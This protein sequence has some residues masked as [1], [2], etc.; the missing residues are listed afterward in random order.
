MLILILSLS[1][2]LFAVPMKSEHSNATITQTQN[3]PI[4]KLQ[5]MY[6]REAGNQMQVSLIKSETMKLGAKATPVLIKVMKESSY[7]E[8]NRWIATFMLGRVMGKKASPFIAKFAKH[9]HWMMRVASLK[10]LL[11]L[12]DFRYERIFSEALK[13]ESLMVRVQALQNISYMKIKNLGPHVWSMLYD[14]TN[15]SGSKGNYKRSDIVKNI[16][17]TLGD[18]DY[19]HAKKPLLKMVQNKK[20]NDVFSEL[21]YTLVKLTNKTSPKGSEEAKRTFWAKI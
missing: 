9:P 17:K 6:E 19:K 12:N 3:D 11:H 10:T 21:D 7:P 13:D 14:K 2:N 4:L 8:K 1:L 18:I 16:I 20:Y 5:K 15:Y